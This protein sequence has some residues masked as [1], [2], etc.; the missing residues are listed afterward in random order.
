MGSSG[1]LLSISCEN[2]VSNAWLVFVIGEKVIVESVGADVENLLGYSEND[3][4]T[5]SVSFQTL[6]HDDDTEIC[7]GLFSSQTHQGIFTENFR[8]RKKNNCIQCVKALYKKFRRKADDRIVLQLELQDV[9]QLRAVIEEKFLLANF[10]A[11]METTDDY[12]YFKDRNHVFTGASQTLVSLTDPSE[13]WTDLIGLTDYD[14]FPESYADKYYSL[15]KQIFSGQV[16]IAH[17]TQPTLDNKGNQGWVDNRKY[18]IKDQQGN[19]IGLFGIARDISDI[20]QLEQ[21]LVEKIKQLETSNKIFDEAG[22]A[23]AL[24]KDG[25][26]IDCN[27]AA[28]KLFNIASKE[29]FKRESLDRFSPKEQANGLAS[30]VEL[31]EKIAVTLE[32]G[33]HRFEWINQ[34]LD[35]SVF[36]AEITLT[37]IHIDGD[38]IFHVHWRDITER[39]EM[40]QEIEW[41]ANHDPLTRLPNRVLLTTRFNL[42]IR[43][44]KKY[45][46]QLLVCMLDLDGF[47]PVNDN[48]GHDA[49]DQLIIAVAQ[50]LEKLLRSCD[51]VCRMGGDEFALLLCGLDSHEDMNHTLQRIIDS[52]AETYCIDEHNINITASIGAVIFPTD[53]DDPDILLRHADQA[54]YQAKQ[55]GRNRVHWFDVDLDRAAQSSLDVINHVKQ[56]LEKDELCFFYQ[57]KVNMATQQIVG[58]EALLRWLHPE[59]G[60]LPPLSFLPLVEQYDVIVEIGEWGIHQALTQIKRWSVKGYDWVVSVNIAARHF[61]Q[62]DFYQRFKAI[63]A[64]YPEIPPWQLEIEI[65]ESVSINDIQKVHELIVNC[66]KL[67]V[68]FALD[69]FG[70]GYSSLSYLK[71]LPANTIKIDQSFVRDILDDKNDLSLVEAVIGLAR[72][73]KRN[74][75]AEGVETEAHGKRLLELGCNLAQGYG[76][77]RPMPVDEIEVW[78]D[79]LKQTGRLWQA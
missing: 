1:K 30:T 63:L 69:D 70:T 57:P 9:K 60:L 35:G 18:P 54:M 77:A 23:I 19:I 37:P 31:K 7:E 4:L 71:R 12:I 44:A 8:V 32:N 61:Q 73:F 29:G 65:L 52:L 34:R 6:I 11:M 2:I 75:I 15:E 43:D 16:K 38:T 72:S 24:M 3:F 42:A 47:K 40:Q 20:K 45:K 62:A 68:K 66:Q 21:N 74:V 50:R 48:Y 25:H 10:S 49:G 46:E 22:D 33:I 78:A 41:Q 14:V 56:A 26:F 27:K 51:T 53:E 58:M 59:K 13:H 39:K 67:G 28:L 76:I 5:G 64:M 36:D 55:A 17:E 79:R